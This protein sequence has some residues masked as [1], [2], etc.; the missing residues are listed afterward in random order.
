MVFFRNTF[1]VLAS[2]IVAATAKNSL[3]NIKNVVVLV[4]ENR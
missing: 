1:L 2:T 4:Q 3:S